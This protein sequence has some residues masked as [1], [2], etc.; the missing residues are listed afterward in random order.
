MAKLIE[1]NLV[2][3]VSKMVKNTEPDQPALSSDELAQLEAILTEL[4]GNNAIVE[5]QTA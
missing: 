4:A 3:T 5:I 1:Q 2:I